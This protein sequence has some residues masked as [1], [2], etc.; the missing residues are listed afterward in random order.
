MSAN[1]VLAVDAG[2]SGVH[3]LL[4]DSVGHTLS[5]C[6]KEWRYQL[7]ED[8]GPLGREFAP[9][10][11]WSL[12]CDSIK[13]AVVKAG[14]QPQQIVSVSAT[15][16]RQG[17]VFLGYDGGELYAGPNIDIRALTEGSLL[18]DE[19]GREVY[20]ITGHLPSFLFV[21]AKLKWFRANRPNIYNEIA[22]V[23]TIS[24]WVIYRLC[25]ERVSE[26]CGATELGLVNI[27][28]RHWSERLRELLGLPVGIYPALV[29]AGS[30]VGEVTRRAAVETGL[31]AGTPVV[32]GAPDTHCALIAMGVK[33]KRQVG[34][35][36][37]WSAPVQI[38]TYEPILDP[39]SR[40][41]TSCH[42][43]P[44]RW[45]LESNAGEAGNAYRWLKTVLFGDEDSVKAYHV[46]D[47]L[48]SEVP[49]GAED[50]Q[51]FIG[52]A[53]MDMGRLGM[54]LGGF[55]F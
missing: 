44:E 1:Y 2:T 50:V 41:W 18:D 13:E 31:A 32:A 51:A 12:I 48:A 43:L 46:M 24:D 4:V 53:T 29:P 37:G 3:C 7:P 28:N 54:K 9:S 33:K 27:Q 26:V 47:S 21:P 36:V 10:S 38:V 20:A 45:V 8:T 40:T 42:P 16:Q 19:F 39:E 22:T 5:L 11:F 25:G 55:L 17:V 52:P 14:I 49:A 30:R 15:S 23:L 35:I 34:I 6:Y